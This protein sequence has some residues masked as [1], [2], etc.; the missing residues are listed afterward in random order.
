[1]GRRQ[2]NWWQE[3]ETEKIGKRMGA[4]ESDVFIRLPPFACQFC[5]FHFPATDFPASC[6]LPFSCLQFSCIAKYGSEISR[7][8]TCPGT[9]REKRKTGKL[10]TGKWE[11]TGGRK[12]RG[13]KMKQ[14]ELASEWGQANENVR[15]ACPHSLANFLCFIFLPP[16][17]LPPSHFPVFNF[18]VLIILL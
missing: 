18:P 12:I 7:S 10:K 13:R 17:F 11:E 5:L 1:M 14:T 16:I 3:N 8:A 15:F 2:E 6:F 9:K 4:S